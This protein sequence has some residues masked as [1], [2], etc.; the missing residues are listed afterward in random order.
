MSAEAV[1]ARTPVS[2]RSLLGL[3][4]LLFA[5]STAQTWWADRYDDRL[6][7]R[8][9]ALASPG[10]IRML[11]SETCAVCQLARQWLVE[12]RV[13]FAECLVERDPACR[14]EHLATGAAGTPVFLVRGQKLLGFSAEA[15]KQA[16]E[17]TAAPN[18][19][20]KHL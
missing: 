14:A 15:L 18:A 19:P 10:D 13:P 11:S 7:E 17:S 1:P 6:G 16:L 20:S 2:R 9:A 3:G 4:A 12:H 8:V 5:V